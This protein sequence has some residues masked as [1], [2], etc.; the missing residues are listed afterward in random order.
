MFIMNDYDEKTE[1]WR[2]DGRCRQR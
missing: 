1:K 2:G